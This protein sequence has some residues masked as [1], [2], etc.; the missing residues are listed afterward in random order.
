MVMIYSLRNL[1]SSNPGCRQVPGAKKLLSSLIQVTDQHAERQCLDAYYFLHYLRTL[2]RLFFPIM[3]T[4]LPLLASLNYFGGRHQ[5]ANDPVRGLDTL[6]FGNVRSSNSGRYTAHV[7]CA[8]VVT[9][10]FCYLAF[11]ELN[12]YQGNHYRNRKEWDHAPRA[13]LNMIKSLGRASALS[14]AKSLHILLETRTENLAN[15]EAAATAF[16]IQEQP[17]Y[18]SQIR[19][20]EC[21]EK[22]QTSEAAIERPLRDPTVIKGPCQLCKDAERSW[23]HIIWSNIGLV[24]WKQRL[25]AIAAAVLLASMVLLWAIPV[26]GTATLS[27]LDSLIRN[28]AFQSFLN[29]HSEWRTLASSLAGVLPAI[30]LALLLAI[31]PRVLIFLSW[32]G[33]SRFKFE[34]AAFVQKFF[35]IF[36]FIQMF[37][38]VSIASFFTASLKHFIHNVQSLQSGGD[39]LRLLSE[40]LPTAANY[41]FSYMLLQSLSSSASIALQ[42]APLSWFLIDTL[43]GRAPRQK[44]SRGLYI[45]IV[46]WGMT[47]P[48]YTTLACISLAYCIMAPLISFFAVVSFGMLW[49]AHRYSLI[50][51][52][53]HGLDHGGILYPRA[54]NQTFTGLYMMHLCLAGLLLGVRDE[55]GRQA[56]LVHGIVII[57]TLFLTATFQLSMNVWILP[58]IR[59]TKLHDEYEIDEIGKGNLAEHLELVRERKRP[60]IPA[61]SGQQKK[62]EQQQLKAIWLANSEHL[63]TSREKGWEAVLA[64]GRRVQLNQVGIVEPGLKARRRELFE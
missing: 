17:C 44:W 36:L 21:G 11:T 9:A 45:D 2:L 33:G 22:L 20:A 5:E 23:H 61:C 6:A 15:F 64:R 7:L 49:L 56:C 50:Y 37:L 31:L 38:V 48:L 10:W 53:R 63:T 29:R 39:V 18:K 12:N 14:S 26:S 16:L 51:V 1:L 3:L 52:A 24:R 58:S 8:L 59:R 35:F 60:W 27:Q 25:R 28:D 40:N 54:I 34:Q 42:P 4:V 43:F 30:A 46:A 13:Q 41:F 32:L 19:M 47:F 55:R 62:S 57:V